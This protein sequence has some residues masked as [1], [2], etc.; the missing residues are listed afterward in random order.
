MITTIKK[1]LLL[2]WY[3]IA[4]LIIICAV[5]GVSL[6]SLTPVINKHKEYIE[7]EIARF[8][9]TEIH[10]DHIDARWVRLGPELR[11]SGV[12]ITEDNH[13]ALK[14][15]TLTVNLDV[16]KT[17]WKRSLSFRYI[18]LSG[19][20]IALQE[21]ESQHYLLNNAFV[22]NLAD[23]D[24]TFGK[25]IFS[26][27]IVQNRLRL[28]DVHARVELLNHVSA[29]LQ[30]SEA[31]VYQTANGLS[32]I[33]EGEVVTKAVDAVGK[34]PRM[35]KGNITLSLWANLTKNA[36]NFVEVELLTKHLS[37]Q[38]NEKQYHVPSFSGVLLWQALHDRWW[39]KANDIVLTSST[40]SATYHFSFELMGFPDHYAAHFPE[41]NLEDM[42]LAFDLLNLT[43]KNVD[44]AAANL[45]G[46]IED[47]DVIVPKD[48]SALDHYE[49]SGTLKN[50]SSTAYQQLP[51]IQHLSGAISGNIMQGDFALLTQDDAIYFPTY[52]NQAIPVQ[53]LIASGQ[54]HYS[55]E[56]LSLW[57]R[58]IQVTSPSVKANGAMRLDIPFK[59]PQNTFLSL[60][61]NFHLTQSQDAVKYLP[62][63]EFDTD[64][65]TWL[66]NAIGSGKGSDGEV[67]IRGSVND[68]PYLNH[69]GT[70][71][72]D[73]SIKP[74]QFSISPEWP[75]IKDV[76]GK[77]RF[78]NQAFSADV[79]TNF[80]GVQLDDTKISV[81]DYYGS[82]NGKSNPIVYVDLQA[83]GNAKNYLTFIQASPLKS[84]LGTWLNPF[85]IDGNGNLTLHLELPVAHLDGDHI[86]VAGQ[87]LAHNV[88]FTWKEFQLGLK[89]IS[90]AIHFTQ[91]SVTAT[92]LTAELEKEPVQL[93]LTT[94]KTGNTIAALRVDAEGAMSVQQIET[95]AG[96]DWLS[97]YV[98]GQS[99]YQ[100]S[101]RVPFNTPDYV[102]TLKSNLVGM[103][104][105]LPE[106]LGKTEKMSVPFA[107]NF[108]INPTADTE[109]ISV[110]YQK[111][112]N[113]TANIQH[114]SQ[115]KTNQRV[116]QV[117]AT[118]IAFSWPLVGALP[119][120]SSKDSTSLWQS[121]T[122][123][124]LHVSHLSLYKNNFSSAIISVA[125]Q[126]NGFLWSISA[127]EAQGSVT[128]PN[129]LQH[130]P[131]KANFD[132]LTLISQKNNTKT[133]MTISAK[134]A[135]TWPEFFLNIQHFKMGSQNLG[136]VVLHTSPVVNGVTFNDIQINNKLYQLSSRG[137]WINASKEDKTYLKGLFETKNVGQF[138]K[139]TNVTQNFQAKAGVVN[140]DL[141]WPGSP[142]AFQ[143]KTIQGDANIDVKDGVI[144]VSGD[145]AKM[146]L[147]K[148]LSLFSAQ[149]IQRRLQLNFS[150][151][152]QNGYSFNSLLSKL[153]FQTGNAMVKEGLFD[154]PEAKIAFTGRIGLARQDYDVK[155]VVTPYVTSSLPLIAT[156]AGGPIAGVA[157]YAFDKIAESSIAK[158][159][160]YHY[161]LVGPWSQ[162]KL[163][164]LD[165]QAKQK[166]QAEQDKLDE[167]NVAPVEEAKN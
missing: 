30:L 82:P 7:Q 143:L 18:A 166:A 142:L 86:K 17:L 161:L 135:A 55:P 126:T 50:I 13:I 99:Q 123:F 48:F 89:K 154:G 57:L 121:I 151:L 111:N 19:S 124:T 72:V 75:T 117:D 144:P 24:S 12:A 28:A 38:D 66:I 97:S 148:V 70:F 69:E 65:S 162:P 35:L 58:S 113:A 91:D 112:M 79:A 23:Q 116:I 96:I 76:S 41:L 64:F 51:A 31:D 85:A 155:L 39:L 74:M 156:I 21:T 125:R 158:F 150:D 81:P 133:D 101:L 22:I 164:D 115:S 102:A 45:Q 37:L 153:H 29:V 32:G 46:K 44:F 60:L 146:G 104:I 140:Y 107:L 20:D 53:N 14:V 1:I 139:E 33:I 15:N 131:I 47:V 167:Q 98:S 122:S 118:A 138:L 132:Y 4:S 88:D 165:A 2:F 149:S 62:M 152:N 11:F 26:W 160:S 16:F 83:Q 25:D 110:N 9:H 67:L 109:K 80:Q 100:A 95:L 137:Q 92:K 52:F 147:G 71:I 128:V 54:W 141:V 120:V 105:D 157:T 68:F 10:I 130:Q 163:I 34:N 127:N 8:L 90:G 94:E 5:L 63:K 59:Q 93:N 36:P 108:S 40:S 43:P 42:T 129:D 145:A 136:A 6:K 49:F 77:L 27:L 106:N 56:R 87:W 114:Y 103:K 3:F 84:T 159:T 78:H 119:Q 61:A 134:N 73:G